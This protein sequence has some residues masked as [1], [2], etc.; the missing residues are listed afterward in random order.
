M[1]EITA[2]I[3]ALL[4]AAPHDKGFDAIEKCSVSGVVYFTHNGVE[5]RIQIERNHSA[6]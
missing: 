2:A 4:R 1:S 6:D 3:A 5:Y